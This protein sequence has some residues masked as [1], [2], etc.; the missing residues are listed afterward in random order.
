MDYRLLGRS[1]L[2]VS[3]LCLGTMA[4]LT[5]SLTEEQVRHLDEASQIE[6]GFPYGFYQ[7][8][9]VR[10]IVSGELRDRILV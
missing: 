6:M 4:S 7:N 5:L 2:R 9:M 3:E 8:E 1:G 10:A